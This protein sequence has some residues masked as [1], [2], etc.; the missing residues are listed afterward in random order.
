M[1][2]FTILACESLV[3]LARMK[4]NVQIEYL[5]HCLNQPASRASSSSKNFNLKKDKFN[6]LTL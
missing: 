4:K 1:T 6:I 5:K 2:S 3:V